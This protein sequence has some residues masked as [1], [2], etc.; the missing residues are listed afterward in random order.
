MKKFTF[1]IIGDIA[2]LKFDRDLKHSEKKKLSTDFLKQH[3]HISSVLE[4]IDKVKGR[5][6]IAKTKF[7][8]GKNKRETIYVENTC[9]FK[10]NIDETYFSSRLSEQRKKVAQDICRRVNAKKNKILVM[11][12][13]VGPYP[14]VISKKLKQSGKKAMV[15]SNEINRKASKYAQENVKLNKLDDY[16]KVVQGDAKKL[17]DKIK[18]KFD[19]IV[20]PRPNLKDTF[21]KSAL[22][23]GKKGARFYYNGFGEK[24]EVLDEIA[25]DAGKKISKIKISR[26][27]DIAPY[28]YRWLAVFEK[29]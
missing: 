19:F 9:K 13:G 3:N 26:A 24:Q 15:V 28:K 16:I 23:V 8:A 6:R 4:K 11:F 2:V 12:A 21:L 25:R 14:V 5:L 10:F 27:G 20:M 29:K 22:E 18:E 7:L 1:D 17:P